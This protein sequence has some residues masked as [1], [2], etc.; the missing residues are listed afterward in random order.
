MMKAKALKDVPVGATFEVWGK[1]FTVLDKDDEKVFVLA[2]EINNDLPFRE[3]NEAEVAD[4][5][6]RDS[7]I[8]EFLNGVYLEE[9]YRAGA[10]EN[11]L[12]EFE[13]DLKCTMGQHEYG[14][15]KVKAG[16]LTLEQYG[17]Y[18]DIIP[19]VD[20]SW[21]LATP[22]KTPSRSPL[23]YST[24]LVWYVNSD[25]DYNGSYDSHSYG[26]RP[27][28]TLSPLLLVSWEN[29]ELDENT[30]NNW[31]E[32]IKYLHKWAVE[33]SGKEYAGESPACYDEWL[34][35]EAEEE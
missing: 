3:E 25:G 35:N 29:D 7:D 33:H 11:D 34:D 6:F 9:L 16:L 24:N 8:R 14:S 21:W 10:K 30:E 2:A 31:N 28:L 17:K 12:L 18:Y 32:Y 27:A 23:T 22:W 26:V 1:K 4:N 15:C 20:E 5:D 19:L 13:V